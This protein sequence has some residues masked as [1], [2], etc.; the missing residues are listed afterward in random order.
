[1][2]SDGN[3]ARRRGSARRLESG[4]RGSDGSVL[5][6]YGSP[7]DRMESRTGLFASRKVSVTE[8]PHL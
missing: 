1:M 7:E 8:E 4:A 5:R 2:G 3:P 6:D